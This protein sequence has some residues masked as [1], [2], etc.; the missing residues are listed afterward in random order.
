MNF[1]YKKLKLKE[2]QKRAQHLLKVAQVEA[3][4]KEEA[5][6]L[7]REA[8]TEISQMRGT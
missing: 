6:K 4:L 7:A 2:A 1:A 5:Q 8:Q 3:R